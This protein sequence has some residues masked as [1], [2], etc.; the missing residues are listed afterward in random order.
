MT[1][2]CAPV[3]YNYVNKY[4]KNTSTFDPLPC[5]L[6]SKT[7]LTDTSYGGGHFEQICCGGK[8]SYKSLSVPKYRYVLSQMK[9]YNKV[10]KLGIGYQSSFDLVS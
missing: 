3:F 2:I 9:I 5:L 7:R 8:I 4:N 1:Y 10:V 6:I